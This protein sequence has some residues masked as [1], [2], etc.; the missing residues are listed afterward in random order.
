M[1]SFPSF[2]KKSK[3]KKEKKYNPS[4]FRQSKQHEKVQLLNSGGTDAAHNEVRQSQQ[5]IRLRLNSARRQLT[6]SQSPFNGR[7]KYFFSPMNDYFK[8]RGLLGSGTYGE[9]RL[10]QHRKNN[11]Y[12]A[13][14]IFFKPG[15]S[16]Y[17]RGDFDEI[18]VQ[19][20]AFVM[21]QMNYPTIVHLYAVYEETQSFILIMELCEGG[22][23]GDFVQDLFDYRASALVPAPLTV[24]IK[25]SKQDELGNSPLPLNAR[26]SANGTGLSG[27]LFLENSR[28]DEGQKSGS[29]EALA[30][31]HEGVE[32]CSLPPVQP[33]REPLNEHVVPFVD[34]VCKLP[35]ITELSA[36]V[37]ATQSSTT[38]RRQSSTG[39]EPVNEREAAAIMVDLLG[40]LA[41]MHARGIVHRDVKI[42]NIF[43]YKSQRVEDSLLGNEFYLGDFG[44][45][46][47]CKRGLLHSYCG[48]PVYMAPEVVGAR[49]A[50]SPE[51]AAALGRRSYTSKCDIWSAGV[52]LHVLLTGEY[53]FSGKHSQDTLRRVIHGRLQLGSSLFLGISDEAV[54][55]MASMLERDPEARPRAIDLLLSSPWLRRYAPDRVRQH[56]ARGAA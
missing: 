2:L 29:A 21:R 28:W 18:E 56:L 9:V 30:R 36:A 26:F 12:Y 31:S 11:Q 17:R 22:T 40:S 54:A 43:L 38:T 20:E 16:Q 7:V 33:S 46:K 10:V 42:D 48:S 6:T 3:S 8:D 41:Y 52:V 44:F 24:A 45:S 50:V 27:P 47:R 39:I 19:S 49:G 37:T 32:K 23:L 55:C 1:G 34:T 15:S 51:E 53:P 25:S 5:N 35:K 4:S 14:K 13:A